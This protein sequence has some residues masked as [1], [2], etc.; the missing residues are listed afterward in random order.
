M[1]T[2]RTTRLTL[3]AAVMGLTLATTASAAT[4]CSP[5]PAACRATTVA[6]K[7]LLHLQRPLECLRNR[8][9]WKWLKG[10]ET[11]LT[12]F[13][14]P[15]T[16]DDYAVC[17]YDG[18]G[19]LLEADVPSG[20]PGSLRCWREQRTFFQ[21]RNKQSEDLVQQYPPD[22]LRKLVLKAGADGKAS[23]VVHGK[24]CRLFH[25]GPLASSDGIE[26]L[27]SPLTIQ[28]QRSGGAACWGAVYSFPP[29]LE[30]SRDRFEDTSD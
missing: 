11:T 27:V 4:I 9:L 14:D 16:S 7:A 1:A 2:R 21:Y 28:L 6:G 15:V 12:D 26:T 18:R 13:G 19:L 22:G 24:G 3:L 10:A 5:T 8:L 17:I 25:D 23:I 30:Q 29:A 20:C